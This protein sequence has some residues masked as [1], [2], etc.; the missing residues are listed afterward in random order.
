MV[1]EEGEV[2]L[3]EGAGR[4]ACKEVYNRRKGKD[5]EEKKEKGRKRKKKEE[6]GRKRKKKEG[7]KAEV[8]DTWI[9]RVSF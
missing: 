8:K 1:E 5:K 4:G 2:Y 9:K 3:G 6:K 7:G